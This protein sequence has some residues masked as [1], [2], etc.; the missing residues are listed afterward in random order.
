MSGDETDPFSWFWVYGM[1]M[2]RSGSSDR[3]ALSLVMGN[4]DVAI[5][6]DFPILPRY[7]MTIRIEVGTQR[8]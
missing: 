2:G 8:G 4:A 7:V 6:T 1:L 5:Q 3:Q